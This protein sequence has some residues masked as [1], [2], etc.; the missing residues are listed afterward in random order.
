[1][2]K[3]VKGESRGQTKQKEKRDDPDIGREEEKAVE[4]AVGRNAGKKRNE[5][6]KKEGTMSAQRGWAK[7]SK[8]CCMKKDTKPG[9]LV[10]KNG[11]G[12]SRFRKGGSSA[13][14]FARGGE[15]ILGG[16][17]HA[18]A[19]TQ[20]SGWGGGLKGELGSSGHRT[21]TVVRKK[22]VA[23]LAD[24]EKPKKK[25]KWGLARQERRNKEDTGCGEKAKGHT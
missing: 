25:G 9:T 17:E 20:T 14:L 3:V 5:V 12:E 19:K 11:G 2:Q 4:A 6:V 8:L 24:I 23:R 16:G 13:R 18:K 15:R 10:G 1:M 21:Q 7:K 22:D